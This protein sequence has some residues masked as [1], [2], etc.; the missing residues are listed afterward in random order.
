ME[1]TCPAH[2]LKVYPSP[3]SVNSFCN[4]A[5]SVE[6]STQADR[7]ELAARRTKR[8]AMGDQEASLREGRANM[9]DWV[10]FR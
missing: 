2:R 6:L 4:P 1:Y 3:P 9:L 5:V 7:V 10:G 8:V